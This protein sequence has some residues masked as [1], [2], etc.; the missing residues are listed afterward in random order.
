MP[1]IDLKTGKVD[2]N[3]LENVKFKLVQAK[4]WTVEKARNAVEYVKN[5]P[6]GA[7]K[8]L[9]GVTVV[10]GSVTKVAKSVNRHQALRQEKFHCEREV[11]DHSNGIYLQLKRKLTKADI[12]RMNRLKR[13]KGYNVSEA[14]SEMGMLKR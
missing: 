5:N 7:M 10:A 8:I 2:R 9:G 13:E 1:V 6:E 11:Y 12:D 3:F 14:L 4:D